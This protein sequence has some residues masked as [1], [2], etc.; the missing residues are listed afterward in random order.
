M[1][2]SRRWLRDDKGRAVGSPA[3]TKGKPTSRYILRYSSQ[4]SYRASDRAADARTRNTVL[5]R[6]DRASAPYDRP[7]ILSPQLLALGLALGM[8]VL[9][10]ARRL[11]L[12]GLSG[13][14]IGLYALGL[15]LGA[16]LVALRP[17]M[18][19]FLIPILLIAY[20]APFVAAPERVAR[21]LRR[22]GRRD[23]PPPPIKDVTPPGQRP[24]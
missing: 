18:T 13:S 24:D 4:G 2:R 11:H 14:S 23:P 15:W 21:V 9:L 22:G 12:A 10:P 7:V 19:R 1:E 16:F 6:R 5:G 20:I 3:G 17:G 8:I